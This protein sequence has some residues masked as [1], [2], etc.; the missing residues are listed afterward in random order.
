MPPSEA[1]P[2]SGLY[3]EAPGGTD[4]FIVVDCKLPG[5]TRRAG[6]AQ[7][8]LSRGRSKKTTAKDCAARGGEFAIPGQADYTTKALMVWLPSANAGD[9]EAQYYVG[10]IYQRG[11][12]VA[13]KYSRAA[14]WFRKAAEQGYAKAQMNLAYLYEKGL[15]VKKDPQQA[16]L[17]YRK[18]SGLGDSITLEAN[19]PD[20]AEPQ[21]PD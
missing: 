16:L 4:D 6:Q 14:E 10:E 17:W 3:T 12:D 8:Y 20:M 18:A 9:M 2:I 15:G 21:P 13:P 19:V 5:Q 7:V 11:L 1:R